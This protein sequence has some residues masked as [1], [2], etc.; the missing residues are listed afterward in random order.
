[1]K[2]EHISEVLP[3]VQG[4]PD[5]VVAEREGYTVIDY[6]FAGLDTFD[7]PIRLECRGIKFGPDGRVLARPFHKFHNIN[8]K[9]HTQA[10]LIDLSQPHVI[11]EKLDGSMIHPAIVND[12]LVFMT[13]MGHTDVAK[14][15]E[16]LLTPELEEICRVALLEEGATPIFEYTAPTNRI[17]IKYEKPQLHLLAIRNTITGEYRPFSVIRP[18]AIRMGVEAV[19]FVPSTWKDIH[20]FVEFARMLQGKEGFVLRFESGQWLKLKGEDYVLKHKSKDQIS[21]EKNAL[22]LILTGA[23]DDVLPLLTEEDKA[24]LETYTAKVR[25]GITETADQLR[26]IVN[27]GSKLD[28]KAFAVEH[29]ASV[30]Q[31]LRALA[32]QVR[33]GKEPEQAIRETVLKNTHSQTQV[34]DVRSLFKADW[35]F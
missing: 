15:A 10:H 25:A 4:R 18:N 35:T 27:G 28:Q 13:R 5:F 24:G 31:Q 21:L 12:K 34:D 17:I 20:E 9:A 23:T 3:H 32:F 8:E 29:L 7:E 22:A 26:V 6:V 16:A 14:K 33:K 19:P 1:M 11:M 2:I 30:P